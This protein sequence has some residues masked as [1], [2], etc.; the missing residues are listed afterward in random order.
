MP[1]TGVVVFSSG[2]VTVVDPSLASIP[3]LCYALFGITGGWNNRGVLGCRDFARLAE[4]ITNVMCDTVTHP[5]VFRFALAR[6]VAFP[7]C[8][9]VIVPSVAHVA[10]HVGAFGLWNDI[11]I[12]DGGRGR[13]GV[14]GLL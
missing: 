8:A 2:R 3:T 11:P 13:H 7:H 12:D 6:F 14:V 1:R 9:V 5:C 10:A 4:K